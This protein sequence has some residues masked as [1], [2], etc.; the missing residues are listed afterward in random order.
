MKEHTKQ[1]LHIAEGDYE[2]GLQGF[3]MA[4]YPQAIYMLC[5]AIEKLLKAAQ[6][7]FTQN[8]PQRSH[9][10][11]NLAQETTLDFSD[12]QYQKLTQLSKHYGKVR[13]PDFAQVDYNTKSKAQPIIEEAQNLYLWILHKFNNH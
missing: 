10:L 9:R 3:K 13:Y 7:E 1:W 4:R 12:H 5:Q 6:I 11:E 2:V 8:L